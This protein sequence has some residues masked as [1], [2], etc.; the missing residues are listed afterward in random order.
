MFLFFFFVTTYDVVCI[1]PGFCALPDPL[2]NDSLDEEA[3][4]DSTV[5]LTHLK[6]VS[7]LQSEKQAS[8]SGAARQTCS[9]QESVFQSEKQPGATRQ[10]RSK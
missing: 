8:T 2:V 4:E 9:K 7:A 1:Y 5:M 6:R 10:T 3:S